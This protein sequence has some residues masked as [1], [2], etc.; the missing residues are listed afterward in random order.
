MSFSNRKFTWDFDS[1]KR[2]YEKYIVKWLN[3]AVSWT[4]AQKKQARANL[5]FGNGDIDSEPTADSDNLVKSGGVVK[6]LQDSG[7][8]YCGNA[9]LTTIPPTLTNEYRVFYIAKQAGTYTNFNSNITLAKGEIALLVFKNGVWYKSP[10]D[11]ASL[12]YIKDT[13]QSYSKTDWIKDLS[14]AKIS[15]SGT[16]ITDN[17]E[18]DIAIS[19]LNN[20]IKGVESINYSGYLTIAKFGVTSGS[21]L[22][23]LWYYDTLDTVTVSE[24]SQNHDVTVSAQ[25]LKDNNFIIY[26]S[27]PYTSSAFKIVL[28]PSVI[29]FM[30]GGDYVYNSDNQVSF[31]YSDSGFT[32]KDVTSRAVIINGFSRIYKYGQQYVKHLWDY[33]GALLSIEGLKEEYIYNIS[34]FGY[35]ASGRF[36]IV[37]DFATKNQTNDITSENYVGEILFTAESSIVPLSGIK[38]VVCKD[39]YGT[40][41]LY[42]TVDFGKLDNTINLSQPSKYGNATIVPNYSSYAFAR[43]VKQFDGYYH[44]SFERIEDNA[45]ITCIIPLNKGC[46]TAIIR[47]TFDANANVLLA[48]NSGKFKKDWGI[49][50]QDESKYSGNTDVY[51][52]VIDCT[53]YKFL[54][55]SSK[56]TNESAISVQIEGYDADKVIDSYNSLKFATNSIT[57]DIHLF[58]ASNVNGNFITSCDKTCK[59]F[60]LETSDVANGEITDSVTGFVYNSGLLLE[61]APDGTKYYYAVAHSSGNN[62]ILWREKDGVKTVML[63]GGDSIP[64]ANGYT[65]LNWVS[66]NSTE[67]LSQRIFVKVMPNGFVLVGT[68]VFG[69]NTTD[70]GTGK[71]ITGRY[72]VVF[73]I[74]NDGWVPKIITSNQKT[75]RTNLGYFIKSYGYPTKNNSISFGWARGRNIIA[76]SEYGAQTPQYWYDKGQDVNGLGVSGKVWVSLDYGNTFYKVFDL[77]EKINGDADDI[78]D[79]NWKWCTSYAGRQGMHIHCCYIDQVNNKL[80]ITNGDYQWPDSKNSLYYIDLSTLVDLILGG[81]INAVDVTNFNPLYTDNEALPPFREFRMFTASDYNNAVSV[82]VNFQFYCMLAINNCLI[83]GN[84]AARQIFYIIHNDTI[85][86]DSNVVSNDMFID[87]AYE[88]DKDNPSLT[89]VTFP[90]LIF[91]KD[92]N[93]MII[94]LWGDKGVYGSWNGVDWSNLKPGYDLGIKFTSYLVKDTDGKYIICTPST[95]SQKKLEN[96]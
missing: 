70:P 56:G 35:I 2:F 8:I 15:I 43:P 90:Q 85:I 57:R 9:Y 76:I 78:S 84:D 58:R 28:D 91:R 22:L 54:V 34:K 4:E 61:V 6:Y 71:T 74:T 53:G 11:I 45:Y 24:I 29:D 81:N 47:G 26:D 64:Q 12:S 75:Y 66:A 95:H 48:D 40:N 63:R 38:R 62:S 41:V 83:L 3:S 19:K 77:D 69:E 94:S 37:I 25:T 33:N 93:S 23:R 36:G 1:L 51:N 39:T 20:Y 89:I 13:L 60:Q 96:Y 92:E 44:A 82:K 10:V 67:D 14:S 17:V 5:G 87:I 55:I 68:D 31:K 59:T 72:Y 46:G 86:K 30:G 80:W 16:V 88:I 18:R 42:V 27:I 7:F 73:R 65:A 52:C 49:K 79:N 32:P 50:N 21:L